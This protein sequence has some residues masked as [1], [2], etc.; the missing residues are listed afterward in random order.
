MNKIMNPYGDQNQENNAISIETNRAVAEVQTGIVLAKRFGRTP[1]LCVD[2]ILKECRRLTLAE[3]ALYSYSRGGTEITAPSIRLAEVIARNWGNI[4]YGIK[5]IAQN[6]SQGESEMMAYAW[7]LETNVRQT[8]MFIVKHVR[9]TKRG[10]Y[11]LKDGRDIYETTANQGSRRLRACILGIIPG[12]VVDVAV[13]Q[14]EETLKASV[15]A[16]PAAI[17]KMI[18]AFNSFGVNKEMIEKRIQ[19][20]IDT[21]I[22][23]QI[24]GLR[25]IYTSLR[26]DMSVPSD[27]FE[28][29]HAEPGGSVSGVDALRNALKKKSEPELDYMR[30]TQADEKSENGAN[31]K[32]KIFEWDPCNEDLQYRYG[33]DKAAIIKN[34]CEKRKINIK[35]LIPRDA[36][37]LLLKAGAQTNTQKGPSESNTNPNATGPENT[38]DEGTALPDLPDAKSRSQLNLEE[39]PKPTNKPFW[40]VP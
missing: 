10:S 37:Q 15:D 29:V 27:W 4:D 24:I 6:Q 16:S 3:K 9:Y 13:S 34:E 32:E 39:S 19:R 30:R 20:R 12:D 17:E 14:C 2:R 26:D 36:H 28:I 5:E 7:D 25:K 33:A 23:A 22:P 18:D 1:Q 31:T 40:D 35:G 11:A 38:G 21:I 8:K